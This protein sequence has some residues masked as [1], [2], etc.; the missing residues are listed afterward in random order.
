MQPELHSL[1]GVS[2]ILHVAPHRIL[3]LLSTRAVPEPRLR[4][5]GRRLWSLE[6][7]ALLAEKLKIQLGT[8]LERRRLTDGTD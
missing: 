2:D 1:S 8:E 3:Y 4:V 7:I 5:G 6:E